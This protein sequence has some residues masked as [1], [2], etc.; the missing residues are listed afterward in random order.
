MPVNARN[1]AFICL[2]F[3]LWA[4]LPAQAAE[5]GGEGF[6]VEDKII[7]GLDGGGFFGHHFGLHIDAA[8]V[9]SGEDAPSKGV[10]GHFIGALL[11]IHVQGRIPITSTLET[12][13]GIGVDLWP[14]WGI[15]ANELLYGLPIFGEARLYAAEHWSFFGRVRYYLAQSERIRP[16]E[17]FQGTTQTPVIISAGFGRHF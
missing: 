4:A 12:R 15:D 16:G 9:F 11:G 14:L 13:A 17:N 8:L 2:L 10:D 5:I 6:L 1:A 7:L 3:T